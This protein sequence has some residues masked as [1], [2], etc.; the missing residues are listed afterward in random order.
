[1]LKNIPSKDIVEHV[2]LQTFG[3][4]LI[5]DYSNHLLKC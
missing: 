4:D 5:L 3:S 2:Q 1:M